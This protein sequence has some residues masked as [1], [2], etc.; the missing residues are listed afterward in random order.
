MDCLAHCTW[1]LCRYSRWP[2]GSWQGDKR[3]FFSFFCFIF[4]L[5]FESVTPLRNNC[6]SVYMTC[7]VLRRFLSWKVKQKIEI[8]H[9]FIA[10]GFQNTSCIIMWIHRFA[11]FTPGSTLNSGPNCQLFKFQFWPDKRRGVCLGICFL[12]LG[13]SGDRAKWHSRASCQLGKAQSESDLEET[14]GVHASFHKELGWLWGCMLCLCACLFEN[15]L[16]L[17]VSVMQ[18]TFITGFILAG[19]EQFACRA[20][21][22]SLP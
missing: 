8:W 17:Y 10:K 20:Y 18:A 9:Y 6:S 15:L 11:W 16:G 5:L 22:P 1:S 12:H 3:I 4:T 21:P 13:I 7:V 14:R 2:L 19:K